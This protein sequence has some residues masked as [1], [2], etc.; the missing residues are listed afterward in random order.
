MYDVDTSVE[1]VQVPRVVWVLVP[2]TSGRVFDFGWN[3]RPRPLFGGRAGRVAGSR[4]CRWTGRR[5]SGRRTLVPWRGRSA[6]IVVVRMQPGRIVDRPQRRGIARIGRRRRGG[7]RQL[8][9]GVCCCLPSHPIL[10]VA[11]HRPRPEPRRQR[12]L[13]GRRRGGGGGRTATGRR[14]GASARRCAGR[15]HRARDGTAGVRRF[16]RSG[17]TLGVKHRRNDRDQGRD[18]ARLPLRAARWPPS[19]QLDNLQAVSVQLTEVSVCHSE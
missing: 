12:R 4:R 9:G 14:G 8:A 18:R 6:A 1:R 3:R 11:H 2:Y 15:H 7:A 13:R 5:L 16:A 17:I 19:K 10:G